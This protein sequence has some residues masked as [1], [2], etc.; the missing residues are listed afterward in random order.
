MAVA[1][2]VAMNLHCYCTAWKVS[3]AGKKIFNR[4]FMEKEFGLLH[5]SQMAEEIDEEDIQMLEAAS[6]PISCPTSK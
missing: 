4:E 5:R 1:V 2:A 3:K 6:M